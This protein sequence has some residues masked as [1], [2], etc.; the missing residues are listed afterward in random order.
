MVFFTE[1]L[2]K[3]YIILSVQ[4]PFTSRRAFWE[5]LLCCSFEG[6]VLAHFLR[7]VHLGTTVLFDSPVKC[8]ENSFTFQYLKSLIRFVFLNAN[9]VPWEIWGDS[10]F[11]H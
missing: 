3:F 5:F 9:V 8:H 6:L 4:N 1:V 2:I 10:L 11:W 7:P